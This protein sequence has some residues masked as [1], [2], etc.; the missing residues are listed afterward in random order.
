MLKKKIR[1]F[2]QYCP[3]VKNYKN[4][5]CGSTYARIFHALLFVGVVYTIKLGTPTHWIHEN[6]NW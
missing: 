5:D 3:E 6:L 1:M 2:T 4:A